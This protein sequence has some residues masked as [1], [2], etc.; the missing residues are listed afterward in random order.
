MPVTMTIRCTGSCQADY[1]VE[2]LD[3]GA[4]GIATPLRT[5]RCPRLACM[6]RF[7]LDAA[8]WGLRAHEATRA[9][10]ENLPMGTLDLRTG[11]PRLGHP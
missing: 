2:D 5:I 6:A 3:A 4:L 11:P 9:E 8:A 10:R 7:D 1:L